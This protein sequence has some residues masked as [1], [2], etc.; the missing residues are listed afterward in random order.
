MHAHLVRRIALVAVSLC[1][2]TACRS[3]VDPDGTV[4]A[5]IVGSSLRIH[6]GGSS[7]VYYYPVERETAAAIE[8]VQCV[9]GSHCRVIAAESGITIP[10]VAVNGFDSTSEEVLVYWWH[11][12]PGPPLITPR[13][14]QLQNVIARR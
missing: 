9:E 2:S 10:L 6:N 13:P 3:P 14:G 4:A 12:V 1:L 8:W 7:P 11:R 5:S